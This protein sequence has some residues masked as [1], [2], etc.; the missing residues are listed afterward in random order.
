M[1]QAF[2]W[3]SAILQPRDKRHCLFQGHKASGQGCDWEADGIPSWSGHGAGAALSACDG[4]LSAFHHKPPTSLIRVCAST[5]IGVSEGE[6][7]SPAAPSFV[8]LSWGK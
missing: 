6:L 5:V 2:L 8:L 7:S 1:G 4:N 3:P